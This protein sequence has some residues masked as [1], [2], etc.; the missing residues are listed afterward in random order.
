MDFSVLVDT[1]LL[2]ISDCALYASAL[3]CSHVPRKR[4]KKRQAAPATHLG[5]FPCASITCKIY[6]C[7]GL[8]YSLMGEPSHSGMS[9]LP[10]CTV[11]LRGAHHPRPLAAIALLGG[12]WQWDAELLLAGTCPSS[13]PRLPRW[14]WHADGWLFSCWVSHTDILFSQQEKF[15]G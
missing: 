8:S 10:L 13:P 4:R 7:S 6:S 9:C 14:L 15:L 2:L 11:P 1:K 12:W 3:K 5:C